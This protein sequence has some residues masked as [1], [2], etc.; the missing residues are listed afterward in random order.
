[1]PRIKSNYEPDRTFF[2]FNFNGITVVFFMGNDGIIVYTDFPNN[3]VDLSQMT[4]Q[5]D[6]MH[7]WM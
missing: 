5:V 2:N 4:F 6:Y 7:H 3:K 1:M